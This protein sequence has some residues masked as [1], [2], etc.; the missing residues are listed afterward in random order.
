MHVTPSDGQRRTATDEYR[1][2]KMQLKQWI[3]Y[4]YNTKVKRLQL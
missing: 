3:S 4:A 2:Q 1:L